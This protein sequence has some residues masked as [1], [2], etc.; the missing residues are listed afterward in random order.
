MMPTG[1]HPWREDY[2]PHKLPCAFS[3][4]GTLCPGAHRENCG[5]PGTPGFR[6]RDD[7]ECFRPY[8]FKHKLPLP[9]P[10]IPVRVS[11]IVFDRL[12]GLKKFPGQP[13][14]DVIENFL[15]ASD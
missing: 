6:H 3:W 5:C 14:S 13:L 15:G 11:K 7:C 1:W 2:E 12:A 10:D 9:E 8:V 4:I